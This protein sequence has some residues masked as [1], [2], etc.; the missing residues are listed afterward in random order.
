[1]E[2]NTRKLKTASTSTALIPAPQTTS[3]LVPAPAGNPTAPSASY[4]AALP[5]DRIVPNPQNPRREMADEGLQEL[6]ESIRRLNV[7]S[8]ILVMPLAN[9]TYRIVYGERRFRAS[10][11]AGKTTIPA[12]VEHM[13]AEEAEIRAIHENIQRENMTP[14]DEGRAFE[15]L[16]K[17]RNMSIP[18]ICATFA[19][20]RA[21]VENRMNLT[22]LIPEIAALLRQKEITLEIAQVLAKYDAQVQKSTYEEHFKSEGW[23]S[24]RGISAKEL[25][26][27]LFNAHLTKLDVY[28]F[29]KTECKTCASNTGN[30]VLFEECGDCAACRNPKCLQ[31]KNTA[32]LIEHAIALAAGDPYLNL[33]FMKGEASKKVIE[34]IVKKGHEVKL[35]DVH[36][37]S[38]TPSRAPL[39]PDLNRVEDEDDRQ[40]RQRRYEKELED[41]KTECAKLDLAVIKGR[42]TKYGVIRDKSV[43]IYYG[44]VREQSVPAATAAAANTEPD[45]EKNKV[46]GKD[47]RNFEIRYEHTVRDLKKE[48]GQT[49]RMF[50]K[51]D[52]LTPMEQ[53]AFHFVL[54]KRISSSSN[55]ALLGM[56]DAE[57]DDAKCL[58]HAGKITEKQKNMLYRMVIADYLSN[59]SESGCVPDR[60]SVRVMLDFMAL[61]SPKRYS[62]ID[63]KYKETYEKHHQTLLKRAADLDKEKELLRLKELEQTLQKQGLA[64]DMQTGEILTLPAAQ[65]PHLLPAPISAADAVEDAVVVAQTPQTTVDIP[66]DPAEVD[67]DF[68]DREV[69]ETLPDPAETDPDFIEWEA[70]QPF[71]LQQPKL[72]ETE[73]DMPLAA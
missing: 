64:V 61:H 46:L 42:K 18:E 34:S 62:E 17:K 71:S 45:T 59:I 21:Y 72:P 12:K 10:Q 60:P 26:R 51:K 9:G 54:L 38:L 7:E 50:K 40:I 16:H 73:I 25:D 8:P 70:V 31:Q 41:H 56:K 30:N 5:L 2:S 55:M 68:I 33:V 63:R 52:S 4:I 47:K 27:R 13:T 6:A 28:H 20:G 53:Q 58:K 48:I 43:E 36:I 32:Y 66:L 3:V 11:L 57:Y 69:P 29:D 22:K 39:A 49:V 1:M 24:W 14:F 23:Y 44:D 37:G 19:K 15:N 67:S 35:L 65:A